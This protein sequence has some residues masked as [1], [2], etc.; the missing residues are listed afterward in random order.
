MIPKA[1]ALI[2]SLLAIL[3]MTACDPTPRG[4][5]SPDDMADLLVDIHK[6]DAVIESEGQRYYADSARRQLKDAIL[7]RHNVSQAELDSSLAW[8]GRNLPEYVK[9]YDKVIAQLEKDIENNG[10][11][12]ESPQAPMQIIIDSD[13]ANLWP[14]INSRRLSP[15]AASDF[16]TF[17]LISDRNWSPGDVYELKSRLTN[18]SGTTLTTIAVDYADGTTER[19]VDRSAGQGWISSRIY[20]DP[21]KKATRIY[22]TIYHPTY[23]GQITY[24]D[25]ISLIRTRHNP[26]DSIMRKRQSV[27][28]TPN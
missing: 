27:G 24:I 15:M 7:K 10:K 28:K 18:A 19:M 12:G 20:L 5:L 2:L 26:A 9:V 14:G 1:K 22:G 17:N 21:N 25:S 16:I 4:V 11:A 13:S 23:P 3:V 6:G 8:Y